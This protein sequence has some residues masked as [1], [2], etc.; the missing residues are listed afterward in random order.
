MDYIPETF[1]VD[2]NGNV[3]PQ[4]SGDPTKNEIETKFVEHSL[5]AFQ[6][7]LKRQDALNLFVVD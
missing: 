1:Y 5:R 4:T 3:V 2:R 6:R 7:H